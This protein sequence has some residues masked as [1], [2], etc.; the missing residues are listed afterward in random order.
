[1]NAI[2]RISLL[3]F[4]LSVLAGSAF[5]KKDQKVSGITV[6]WKEV[7]IV[8]QTTIQNNAGGGKIREVEKEPVNSGLVYRAEVKGMDGKWT[9]V[10]VT[11]AGALLRVEPDNAHNKRK[12]K[13]LFGD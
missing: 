7:P 4:V 13:P 8:A 5:A 1:M 11:D 6:R 12:H 10:Y 2:S 9:R 3:V